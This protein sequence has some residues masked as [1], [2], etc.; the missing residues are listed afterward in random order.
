MS[1]TLDRRTVLRGLF[2][3]ISVAV[4]LPYL[5]CF[6]TDNGHLL[7]SGA[8]L[9]TRFGT[10]FWGLGCTPGRWHPDKIG[11]DYD[12][13]PELAAMAPYKNK[14]TIFNGFDCLL[15]GKPN[16]PHGTGG[17]SIR[18]GTAPG[19]QGMLPGASFDNIIANTIG[20]TTR[21]RT[22]D[23]SAIG[24]RNNSLSGNGVGQA[25]P[26][27]TNAVRL[28]QRIFGEG[29]ADPNSATFTP[30]PFVMARKSVLSVVKDQRRDLEKRLGTADKARLDQYFTGVRQVESQLEIQLQKPEPLEACK[31][32][33]KPE[34]KEVAN[35][36][37]D[38]IQNH[39]VM[40]RLVAMALACNQ[41]KVFNMAFNN[42]ASSLTRR[43]SS[44]SHHQLTHDEPRDPA[45]GYQP[46]ATL[47]VEDIMKQWVKFLSI[48]DG[49]PEGDGTL[50]DH[51]LVVAHSETEL[52][53]NHNVS[54]MPIMM[55]GRGSGKVKSGLCVDGKKDPVSRIGLTAMQAMGV[56]I[57]TFGTQS[58]ITK[59]AISELLV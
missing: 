48:L 35:E 58:M 45:L 53:S 20:A 14:V 17:P 27:E 19:N 18:T 11:A 26:P 42:G 49:M 41:T 23:V 37:E 57:D 43:G 51:M 1:F 47:F 10:W 44:T 52:A 50:L 21:F 29:F 36:L 9:P 2:R 34:E 54:N 55:A 33:P 8:P 46:K 28:Y 5:D 4:A 24:D 12:L 40:V 22:I 30:D 16:F 31:I 25:N 38:V 39:E 56:P 15:D 32:P 3:G 13:K 7:A 59:K 6:L